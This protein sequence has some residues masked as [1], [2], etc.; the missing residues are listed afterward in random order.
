MCFLPYLPRWLVSLGVFAVCFAGTAHAAKDQ[1][2]TAASLPQVEVIQGRYAASL[3]TPDDSVAPAWSTGVRFL[4]EIIATRLPEGIG[5]DE[6]WVKVDLSA[7]VLRV[8][9]GYVPV[10]TLSHI[11]FGASGSE[12]LR[13]QGS[14]QTP[15]GEFRVDRINHQSRYR[16][17]FGID[18]PNKAVADQALEK[19]LIGQRDHQYIH[20]YIDRHGKAPADT[21]LGGYIGIHGLGQSDREIHELFDW[22]QGC[23]AVTNEEIDALSRYIGLGTRVII[24]G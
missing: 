13:L 21:V 3:T 11:A 6:T 2:L 4:D 9:K 16:L 24:F 19:G 23:V 18:Y 20:R 15:V 5:N 12:A 10:K 22:T 8:Y 14:N 7:R 1:G 17:F